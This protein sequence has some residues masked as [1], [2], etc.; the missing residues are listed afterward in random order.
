MEPTLEVTVAVL[1]AALLHACWNAIIKSG[2]DPLLDTALVALAGTAVALPLTLFF[3]APAPAARPYICATVVV[4]IGYYIAI[5]AAYR[6]GD[7]SLSYPIMR[8]VAPLLVALAGA[9]WLGERLAANVWA[10]VLLISGGVLSLAF[11]GRNSVRAAGK[12]PA[13]A[14]LW[15]LAGAVIS[16]AYTLIDAAGVR[17][18]GGTER[19]VV[20]LF[21]F[22]GLPFGLAV[23]AMKRGAFL[24]HAARNWWRGLAGCVMSG[25]S[26]GIA[27]WAT[28]R[29]PVAVVAA[30]RETSVI[31]AAL[32]GAWLLKEGHLKERLVGAAAVLAGLIALKL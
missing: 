14:T 23:L 12:N 19:Y 2:S 28:T 31:F 16:A 4:H 26:Y 18:S 8:G 22:L 9:F 6:A 15:A 11:A 13:A 32:I 10:G 27:L 25:L 7:L 20:W 3:E 29:A 21:V 1:G 17:L 30:L 24:R 5:A